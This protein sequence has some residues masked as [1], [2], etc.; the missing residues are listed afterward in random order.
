MNKYLGVTL[1]S[2]VVAIALGI[3]SAN[4]TPA[5][6]QFEYFRSARFEK[7]DAEVL[8]LMRFRE[9]PG[10]RT[11]ELYLD[12]PGEGLLSISLE[13]GLSP[14]AYSRTLLRIDAPDWWMEVADSY[15]SL[16]AGSFRTILQE[17]REG[18]PYEL[19]VRSAART[20]GFRGL[21]RN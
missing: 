19:S 2:A 8:G 18:I 6:E 11:T 7:Y 10:T 1:T 15:P 17:V 4:T 21:L 16:K 3:A 13:V 5:V 12:V 20:T 9:S 14:S